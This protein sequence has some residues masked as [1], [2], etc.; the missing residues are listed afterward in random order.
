MPVILI[1]AQVYLGYSKL[2]VTFI[3]PQTLIAND[4]KYKGGYKFV[5]N[6]QI[7]DRKNKL[8]YECFGT[9]SCIL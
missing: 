2:N 5:I 6:N 8:N 4:V 1:N 9:L 7:F 3:S